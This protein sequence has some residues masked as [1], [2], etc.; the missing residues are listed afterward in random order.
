MSQCKIKTF[1]QPIGNVPHAE[2][3]ALVK[4]QKQCE[5]C[6]T[7]KPSVTIETG[8]SEKAGCIVI[9]GIQACSP[10]AICDSLH[11]G[12][13]LV[14]ISGRAISKSLEHACQKPLKR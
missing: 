5:K 1:Q 10:A 12:D 13:E 4:N 6:K 7:C 2:P 14:I 11:L 3:E 9:K 8:G